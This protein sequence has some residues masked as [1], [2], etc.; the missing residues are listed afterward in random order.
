MIEFSFSAKKV[1]CKNLPALAFNSMTQLIIGCY[2]FLHLTPCLFSCN[3]SL[4]VL[5]C[6][7]YVQHR[8]FVCFFQLSKL[9]IL[10]V[11]GV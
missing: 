5:W 9:L 7:P 11:N 4:E 1:Q 6:I 2:E 3:V 8:G 10:G